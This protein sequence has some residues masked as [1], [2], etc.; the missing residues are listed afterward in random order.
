MQHAWDVKEICLDYCRKREGLGAIGSIMLKEVGT[1]WT[2]F[3]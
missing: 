1:L 3:V 2:R